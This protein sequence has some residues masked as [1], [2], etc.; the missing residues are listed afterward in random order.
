M[1]RGAMMRSQ[2]SG[3]A[4]VLALVALVGVLGWGLSGENARAAG[5]SVAG[6][7]PNGVAIVWTS[8]DPDVAHRMVLMYAGAAK[9][10][11]WFE[12]VR[13]VIWGPSQRLVVGDKDI[14]ASIDRLRESGVVVEACLACADLYGIADDLRD[15]GLE[16]RYMGQPLTEWLKSDGWAVMTY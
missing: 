15:A 16:V 6:G 11:G 4:L 13:L 3:A 7:S 9:R 8:G 2:F 12:E 10:N 14:R 5:A 1:M